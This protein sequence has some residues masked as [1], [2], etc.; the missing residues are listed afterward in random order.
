M[1]SKFNSLPLDVVKNI[2]EYDGRIKYRNGVFINRFNKDDERYKILLQIPLK[3][4]YNP[5]HIISDCIFVSVDF[6][7][8]SYTLNLF[9]WLK[10]YCF[11][12]F[13]V[14]KLYNNEY[15]KYDYEN[16]IYD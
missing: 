7:N 10:G 11:L 3:K 4:F 1:N 5:V 13:T 15:Y 12:I 6:T 9:Y 14:K 8:P 16:Y 2:L